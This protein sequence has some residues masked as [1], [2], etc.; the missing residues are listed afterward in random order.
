MNR[1]LFFSL[2]ITPKHQKVISPLHAYKKGEI[3]N[4]EYG[5]TKK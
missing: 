3:K 1:Q 4:K 2:A 5:I